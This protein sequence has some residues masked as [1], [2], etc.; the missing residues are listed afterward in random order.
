MKMNLF[1]AILAALFLVGC[2]EGGSSD[3]AK[4]IGS[5]SGGVATTVPSGNSVK[6]LDGGK[7]AGNSGSDSAH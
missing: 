4:G 5:D 3:T 2:G 7:V 1:Y 6:E